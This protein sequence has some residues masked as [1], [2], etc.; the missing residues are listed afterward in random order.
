MYCHW[1]ERFSCSPAIWAASIVAQ[2]VF[3]NDV[4]TSLDIGWK[5]VSCCHRINEHLDPQCWRWAGWNLLCNLIVHQ[6]YLEA[7]PIDDWTEYVTL[8]FSFAILVGQLV[9]V[10]WLCRGCFWH[11]CWTIFLLGLRASF[12]TS[13]ALFC[14]VQPLR[15]CRL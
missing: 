9:L 4:W 11:Y 10:I 15:P 8:S 3:T 1:Y 14:R 7:S 2:T 13:S 5:I 12:M 6:G